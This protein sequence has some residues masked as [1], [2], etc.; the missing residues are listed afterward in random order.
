MEMNVDR[1]FAISLRYC[2]VLVSRDAVYCANTLNGCACDMLPMHSMHS[3]LV[4]L[5]LVHTQ[6]VLFQSKLNN[7]LINNS[8]STDPNIWKIHVF[9]CVFFHFAKQR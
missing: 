9:L 4:L 7:S 6:N 3:M 2:S 5:S 8:S 1:L